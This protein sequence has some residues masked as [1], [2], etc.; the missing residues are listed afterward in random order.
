[1]EK[2]I[3]NKDQVFE[4]VS[5]N[6]YRVEEGSRWLSRCIDGRYE[7]NLANQRSTLAP[8][9]FPA[10]DIGELA[11]LLAT[12][13]SYGFTVDGEKAVKTLLEIVGGEKNFSMHSD[14][15][16][17]PKMIASGCGHYK[18]IK[19]D[20][21]AYQITDKE[22]GFIDRTL[23]RLKKG[24]AKEIILEGDHLEA[25]VLMVSCPLA[26][27]KAIWAI[28]PRYNLQLEEGVKKVE[29]FVYHQTLVDERH[30]LLAEKLIKNKA[31]ELYPGC[32]TDYLYQV[33]SEMAENHLMETAKRLA[34][35]LP[36]YRVIFKEDGSFE[37]KEQ[38][39]V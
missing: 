34:K 26:D 25:A 5:A 23:A 17:D 18:M 30:R 37:I 38:G 29:V 6:R 33:L 3:L 15:H 39:K 21:S 12:A 11:L 28:A 31:V 22:I 9:A 27:K 13:S 36:I 19:S 14:N 7:N 16:G 10:G 24:G 8:L 20:P 35:G 4:I 2:F 1:M 32:D